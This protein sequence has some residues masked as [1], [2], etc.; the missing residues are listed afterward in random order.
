MSRIMQIGLG[1]IREQSDR[2]RALRPEVV[3]ALAESM[4]SQGQL[5]PIIVTP[6]KDSGYFL[7]AGKHRREAARMLEWEAIEAKVI[8]GLE[9]D[10]SEL[11]QIDE[12]LIRGDLSP[13]ER[14]LHVAKRKEIYERLYPETKQGATGRRGKKDANLAS[15]SETAAKASG[16]SKRTVARDAT[17]G[18]PAVFR[19][20]IERM[21]PTLPKLEMYARGKAPKGGDFWGNEAE[22]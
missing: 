11:A 8:D 3:T 2:L 15:F 18:K 4:K 10:H 5:Q 14:A 22:S 12:N 7:V 6:G 20:M 19:E 9:L 1:E 17:R 21:F 16:Q 13:A